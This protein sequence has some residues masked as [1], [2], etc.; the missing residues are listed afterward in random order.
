MKGNGNTTARSAGPAF[1]SAAIA[2]AT[3][4]ML[5]GGC[6]T[7]RDAVD[8]VRKPE[9]RITSAQLDA[10]TFSGLTL[11][12]DVEIRNPNPIGVSLSG[13]DYELQIEGNS[14]VSG[15]IEEAITVAARGRTVVPL[16]VEL[17]FEEVAKTIRE[18]EGKEEAAYELSAGF[19]FGLP[20][21]GTVRV[22]TR[23][24]GTFPILRSPRLKV[25]GLR[26]NRITPS[27]ANLD[28]ELELG[29]GNNFKIFVEALEYRLRV[30][31]TD[32]VSGMRQERVRLSEKSSTR[33]TLP[34]ELDFAEIGRSVY[35]LLLGGDSLEYVLEAEVDLGTSLR[36]LEHASLPFRLEGQLRIQR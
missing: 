6:A 29:N 11:R 13:F 5:A 30:E 23:M 3:I 8:V 26:L 9:V 20:V 17:G 1:L 34:I 32:W 24:A 35:M 4:L 12:F 21:L 7:L 22:P 31:G 15:E 18:I 25:F 27:G 2:A 14:F 16:P 10:L 36:E 33:I 19:S 28:L